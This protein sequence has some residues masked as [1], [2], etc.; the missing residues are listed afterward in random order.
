[1]G[2]SYS[3]ARPRF[4]PAVVAEA[5]ID[6]K[7]KGDREHIGPAEVVTPLLVRLAKATMCGQVT[8]M[9]GVLYWAGWRLKDH[10]PV[11]AKRFLQ[12]APAA[13]AYQVNELYVDLGPPPE[14]EE[15]EEDFTPALSAAY[16]IEGFARH[17]LNAKEFWNPYYPPVSQTFHMAHLV[18]HIVPRTM[19]KGFEKWLDDLAGRVKSVAL[20]PSEPYRRIQDFPTTEAYEAWAARYRGM[21]LPPQILDPEANYDGSQRTSLV[22]QF[23]RELDWRSNPYLRSPEAMLA[24]GFSGT[25]Y[26]DAA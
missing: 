9:A 16:E 20:A 23:L 1:M 10:A 6:F 26:V 17:A 5:P 12:L 13:F 21:P 4:I 3:E 25:P 2:L 18:K 11:P 19:K 8:M 15:Y 14:Y 24:A 7:W 22:G